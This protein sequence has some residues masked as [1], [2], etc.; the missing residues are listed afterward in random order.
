MNKELDE[1][2]EKIDFEG[3]VSKDLSDAAF[4][5]KYVCKRSHVI[6]VPPL[7]SDAANM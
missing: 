4:G 3:T 7:C 2:Q 6:M 5:S 1:G